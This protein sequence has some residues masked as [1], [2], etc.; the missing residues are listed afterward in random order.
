MPAAL[1]MVSNLLANPVV[2]KPPFQDIGVCRSRSHPSQL[3]LTW[4][5]VVERAHEPVRRVPLYIDRNQGLGPLEFDP[6]WDEKPGGPE[7]FGEEPVRHPATV[8]P[9]LV[10]Y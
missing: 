8:K 7:P 9:A 2:G 1:G 3:P 5:K 10:Q 6:G 4:Q